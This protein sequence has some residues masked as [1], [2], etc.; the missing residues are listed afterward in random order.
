MGLKVS[1]FPIDAIAV[2]GPAVLIYRHRSGRDV[3]VVVEAER[4]TGVRI[5]RGIALDDAPPIP[6]PGEL[7][8]AVA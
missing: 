5:L 4:S 6:E 1:L 7:A 3:R 8:L 2:D